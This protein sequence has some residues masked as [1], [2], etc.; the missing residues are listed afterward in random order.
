[1]NEKSDQTASI[2][3]QDPGADRRFHRR[4]L[5]VSVLV[6]GIALLLPLPKEGQL[7]FFGQ[8]LPPLCALKAL[9]G[10][11]CPGCGLTR[12][13]V[14][15]AHLSPSLAW[16]YNRAG[17]LFFLILAAQVPL[18]AWALFQSPPPAPSSKGERWVYLIIALVLLNWFVDL[19]NGQALR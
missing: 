10:V 6:V 5:L 13:F 19:A 12:S 1:M 18:R 11:N 3:P 7:T 14:S 16:S 17:C 2:V 9:T 4:H 15:M 8:P